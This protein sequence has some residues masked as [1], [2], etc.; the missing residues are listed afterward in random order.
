MPFGQLGSNIGWGY[1]LFRCSINVNPCSSTVC[2]LRVEFLD[3]SLAPPNGDGICNTDVIS[4]GGGASNV[5]NLCGEN[6][7]QHVV[8]DFDGTNSIS[9]SIT[10]T[11]AYTFGRHWHIRATQLNCNSENRGKIHEASFPRHESIELMKL[12][13]NSRLLDSSIRLSAILLWD[14][15]HHSKLQLHSIA[16]RTTEFH[17]RWRYSPN[18]QLE[19][20]HLH[21]SHFIVFDH[22]FG[23][24]VGYLF[25]YGD[26]RC[27]CR[28]SSVAWNGNATRAIVHH[29]LHH[30]TESKPRRHTA[31]ERQR[32]LLRSR[33]GSH[34]Q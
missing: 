24:F 17:W 31:H 19:L 22:V 25:V 9:I 21:T 32:S 28:G 34:N 6:S 15:G 2:Q 27:G 3:L 30:H 23:A 16:K 5:P 14:H 20:W 8:V 18:R 33:I 13:M 10:A 1:S 11:V 7:G 26:G 29:R 12:L 4:I